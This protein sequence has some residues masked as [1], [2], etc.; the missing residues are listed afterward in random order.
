MKR[1]LM[2]LV[3]VVVLFG[4]Q[5]SA[6]TYLEGDTIGPDSTLTDDTGG[7][8]A[9][10]NG[11]TNLGQPA[12]LLHLEGWELLEE[13]RV[14]VWGLANSEGVLTMDTFSYNLFIWELADYL[15]EAAPTYTVFLGPPPSVTFTQPDPND[16]DVVVPDTVFGNAGVA[17]NNA[18]TYDFSHDLTVLTTVPGDTLFDEP[19]EEGDWIF[20]YQSLNAPPTSGFLKVS[21]STSTT[22]PIPYFCGPQ[23]EAR[24]V[25]G[26][27]DPN[28]IGAHWGISVGA[29]SGFSEGTIGSSLEVITLYGGGTWPTW[30]GS[31]EATLYFQS[32]K[33]GN[34]H[35][36]SHRHNDTTLVLDTALDEDVTSVPYRLIIE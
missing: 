19:F 8:T 9:V 22:Q 15:N 18:D 16:A 36:V 2:S 10:R 17:G 35:S 1:F 31:D 13:F 33:D 29:R 21:G 6:V 24:D 5:A 4:A 25:L 30:G 32:P 23:Q 34:V 11:A 14:V 20:A 3:F 27:Q 12:V 28:D 7:F 26:G